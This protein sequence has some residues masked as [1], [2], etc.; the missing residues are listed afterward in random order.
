M[1]FALGIAVTFPEL[2]N[3]LNSFVTP[4]IYESSGNLG[5]PLL[6]SVF[7][8]LVSLT[9]AIAAAYLDKKAD[10]VKMTLFSMTNNTK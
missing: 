4:M 5:T 1:A 3:A 7:I 6:V 10:N 9:C 2:G 8:C